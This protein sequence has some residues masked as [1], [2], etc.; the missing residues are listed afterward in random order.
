MASGSD[1]VGGAAAGAQILPALF[2]RGK[3]DYN[4]QDI[5]HS[6]MYDAQA[7]TFGPAGALDYAQQRNRQANAIDQR[8][9]PQSQFQQTNYQQAD[10]DRRRALEAR[11]NQSTIMN[12][13]MARAAGQTPSIAG[14]QAQQDAQRAVAAQSSMA[15]SARGP[16]AMALAQQGAANNAAN[17]QSRI[18]NQSQINAANERLQAEQMAFG[19]ASGMR[20]QDYGAQGQMAQ[21]AQYDAGARNQSN[22]FNTGMRLN[23]RQVNDARAMGYEGMG[24]QGF[25]QEQQGAV[26]MQ[27]IAAQSHANAQATNARTE[28]QNAQ[29][30]GLIDTVGDFFGSDMRMKDPVITSDFNAKQGFQSTPLPGLMGGGGMTTNGMGGMSPLSGPAAA[31]F[32]TLTAGGGGMDPMA[33]LQK[34][35]DF[36]TQFQSDPT[37][38][39]AGGMISDER[40]KRA[41]FEQ[42]AAYADAE[43]AG[44]PIAPPAYA[45]QK[46]DEKRKPQIGAKIGDATKGLT[47]EDAQKLR[48]VAVAASMGPTAAT[49]PMV[50]L[51]KAGDLAAQEIHRGADAKTVP[52]AA[53]AVR[54]VGSVALGPVAGPAYRYI[55]SD[56]TTKEPL[57]GGRGLTRDAYGNPTDGDPNAPQLRFVPG[58][59]W[60]NDAAPPRFSLEEMR[61]GGSEPDFGDVAS[62]DARIAQMQHGDAENKAIFDRTRREMAPSMADVAKDD[63]ARRKMAFEAPD[64]AAIAKADEEARENGERTPSEKI[65]RKP[66]MWEVLGNAGK[67]L[68]EAQFGGVH[69]DRR[70]KEVLSPDQV[71]MRDGSSDSRTNSFDKSFRRDTPA[72]QRRVKRA[73]EDKAGRDADEMMASFGASLGRG[74]SAQKPEG[75]AT[76]YDSDDFENADRG[77]A[78]DLSYA[79]KARD[80]NALKPSSSPMAEANRTMV[81]VPYRYKPEFT[82]PEQ[83][84][85]EVNWGFM[86][87]N[88]KKAAPTA[89][90]VKEDPNGLQRVDALKLLRVLGAGVADLQQ[91]QDETR[92]ALK[93]G[94]KKGS[95]R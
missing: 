12:G 48:D 62:Q 65:G 77:D 10:E 55:T 78:P 49:A 52:Q 6:G 25:Q 43:H 69:S 18:S 90:A 15:A 29:N 51:D 92:L 68:N 41:A 23:S 53:G 28:G 84:P 17:A 60:V 63:A 91:Q 30:K 34:H 76:S 93:G 5:S 45:V 38:G 1:I 80:E 88:L 70:A 72:D 3:S 66:S 64:R 50:A 20:G 19:A 26:Q 81:G 58:Q 42:G 40:A 95:K 33:S 11:G 54:N 67:G 61:D 39:M 71:A 44:K 24:H 21:Q 79:A 75:S 36:A 2:G 94:K 37:G 73:V 74:P 59:G 13:L 89:T 86:A 8:T 85:G 14:M 31:S 32:D 27:G 16:A 57:K 35:S 87:Q 47:G 56:F 7:H 22:Q 82:P 46:P 83:E 9:A 4:A